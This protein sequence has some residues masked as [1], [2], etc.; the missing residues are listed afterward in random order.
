MQHPGAAQL[1]GGSLPRTHWGRC[2]IRSGNP[3]SLRSSLFAEHAAW[4]VLEA[5]LLSVSSPRLAMLSFVFQQPSAFLCH[6][7]KPTGY[8]ICLC[9]SSPTRLGAPWWQ[10]WVWFISEFPAKSPVYIRCS[11]N[12]SMYISSQPASQQIMMEHSLSAMRCCPSWGLRSDEGKVPAL[13]KLA[14]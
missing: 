14:S 6:S 1:W 5:A 11:I 7:L 12:S 3:P 13:R 8:C 2:S 10:G 4:I 9:L